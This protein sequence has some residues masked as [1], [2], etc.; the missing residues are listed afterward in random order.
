MPFLTGMAVDIFNRASDRVISQRVS[1]LRCLLQCI[2]MRTIE[3][4]PSITQYS[5]LYKT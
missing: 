3:E 1:Y 4:S 5:Q 2:L